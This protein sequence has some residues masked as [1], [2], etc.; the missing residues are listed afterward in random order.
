MLICML[1]LGRD[2]L[3]GW[4][5]AFEGDNLYADTDTDILVGHN[6]LTG[7]G[8]R[9]E[10]TL[11]SCPRT[12][13]DIDSLAADVRPDVIL[14]LQTDKCFDSQEDFY[15]DF[16]GQVIVEDHDALIDRANDYGIELI[17]APMVDFDRESQAESLFNSVSALH[18]AVANCGRTYVHCTAGMNRTSTTTMAWLMF[19]GDMEHDDALK[20]VKE[21]RSIADPYLDSIAGFKQIIIEKNREAI[22]ERACYIDRENNVSTVSD[23]FTQAV[24]VDELYFDQAVSE[25]IKE[26]IIENSEALAKKNEWH[27]RGFEIAPETSCNHLDA[28]MSQSL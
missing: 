17:R 9:P 2:K 13:D 20:Q 23:N 26:R 22:E 14:C 4:M 15:P 25:I 3:M 12:T 19:V 18:W 10:L 8:F 1:D 16:P 21:N 24:S 28:Q 5:W 27:Y 7:Y 6:P 11:G